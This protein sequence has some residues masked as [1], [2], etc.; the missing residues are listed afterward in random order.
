M[1]GLARISGGSSRVSV[2][3]ARLAGEWERRSVSPASPAG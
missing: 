3:C 2:F 1:A